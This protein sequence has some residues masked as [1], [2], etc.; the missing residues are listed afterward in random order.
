MQR[1]SA[2]LFDIGD[3]ILTER[4]FD[5]EAGI[6]AAVPFAHERAPL[7]AAAFRAELRTLHH[8][9]HEPLL[10]RWLAEHVARLADCPVD[11]IEDAMWPAVVTLELS[12]GAGVMLRQLRD[13]GVRLG[14]VSNAYFSGRI[15]EHELRRHGLDDVFAFVLTS[16]DLGW[17]KPAAAIFEAAV[18]R[19]DA[20]ASE[21]W[22]VGDTYDEDI[23]GAARA[24]LTPVWMRSGSTAPADDDIHCVND[25]AGLTA[26]W[27]EAQENP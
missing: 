26:L 6:A 18:D 10:A 3:T 23:I 21:T 9:D 17:R 13:A 12:S 5:L 24:G 2:V 19:A 4:R 7:L 11:V 27:A 15:L 25:W 14:A 8:Q 16:G 22:F 20:R 1:P